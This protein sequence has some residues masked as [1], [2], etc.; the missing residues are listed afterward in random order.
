MIESDPQ[1]QVIAKSWQLLSQAESAFD[2]PPCRP[3]IRF[4]LT[5]KSAGMVIFGP[6][7][8]C[9]I[10]Y[11]APLLLRYG[12]RFID[13][14]VPHEVAH[15]VARRRFGQRIKPHGSE[16][17]QIMAFFQV[18]AHRCHSFDTTHSTRRRM[19]YYEYRC[20]CRKHRLSAIRH[21]RMNS[22]ERTYQCRFCGNQLVLA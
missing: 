10:R 11:N 20:A 21:N 22:G 19:R 14:T 7:S 12:Q 13:E 18:P 16:W 17:R 4:D 9:V 6:G 2:L 5:G 3:E 8:R 1:S 15:I